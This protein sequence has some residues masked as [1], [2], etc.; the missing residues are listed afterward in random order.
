MSLENCP[1]CSKKLLSPLASTGRQLCMSC[2]WSDQ[3]AHNVIK[4]NLCVRIPQF[5]KKSTII[6]TS[7]LLSIMAGSSTWAYWSDN[8]VPC[9]MSDDKPAHLVLKDLRSQWFDA[10]ALASSTPR[11][12]LPTQIGRLQEIKQKMQSQNWS[13]CAKP[14]K[15]LLLQSMQSKI[16]GFIEFLNVN[17]SESLSNYY[18]EKSDSKMREFNLEYRKLLSNKDIRVLEQEEQNYKTKARIQIYLAEQF[19]LPLEGKQYTNTIPNIST[20]NQKHELK[21][22]ELDSSKSIIV[23]LAKEENLKSF[24][25][26]ISKVGTIICETHNNSKDITSPKL[27]DNVWSCGSDSFEVK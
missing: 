5:S 21:V 13:E 17:H 20:Q 14:A 23:G 7:L 22:I 18:I 27:K 12:S 2:G 1:K 26:G 11:I 3:T 9:K 4:R 25:G 15:D 19:L 16:D 10:V 6:T 24:A 8:R